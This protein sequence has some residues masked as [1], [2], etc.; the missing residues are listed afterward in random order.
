MLDSFISNSIILFLLIEFHIITSS[1]ILE[2][3]VGNHSIMTLSRCNKLGL[4]SNS[5]KR[6]DIGWHFWFCCIWITWRR[7][8]VH[9]QH[10][11]A[12]IWNF[13]HNFAIF[14]MQSIV[15]IVP[16]MKSYFRI[17]GGI[18]WKFNKLWLVP[19]W[20]KCQKM[21]WHP[22]FATQIQKSCIANASGWIHLCFPLIMGNFSCCHFSFFDQLWAHKIHLG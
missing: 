13:L 5:Q 1:T 17:F 6:C 9:P 20:K 15:N 10:V 19:L 3:L 14:A 2:I 11:T 4:L 16:Q 21:F 18:I 12:D 7:C 22:R 8:F